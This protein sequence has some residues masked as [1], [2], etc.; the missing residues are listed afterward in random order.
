MMIT[1][2]SGFSFA[3]TVDDVLES[4]LP[5]LDY[6]LLFNDAYAINSNRTAS[7]LT[8]GSSLTFNFRC[9]QITEE[10]DSTRYFAKF[11]AAYNYYLSTNPD[12]LTDLPVFIFAPG[13]YSSAIT[14][15]Y[16]TI[17]LGA[18]AGI[19]PNTEQEWT[20]DAIDSFG[21]CFGS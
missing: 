7:A 3:L 6:D 13:T 17:I 15:R 12:I 16:S 21:M 19:N 20:L 1:A 14:V 9:E 10:Y 11:D 18:N 2:F 4:D 5:A 8:S